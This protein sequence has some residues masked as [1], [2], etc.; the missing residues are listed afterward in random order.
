MFVH[1]FESF[2]R[3]M[4]NFPSRAL[5][6]F[7]M[8]LHVIWFFPKTIYQFMVVIF[9]VLFIDF[10]S[11]SHSKSFPRASI[12]SSEQAK[13]PPFKCSFASLVIDVTFSQDL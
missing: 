9:S 5:H 11:A 12:A 1:L 4:L 10:V 7:F 6:I 13:E 8:Q 3:A 2:S